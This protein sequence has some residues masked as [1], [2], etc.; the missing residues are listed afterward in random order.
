[1]IDYHKFLRKSKY[2]ICSNI[3]PYLMSNSKLHLE[4]FKAFIHDGE[5]LNEVYIANT[6]S[7]SWFNKLVIKTLKE[8]LMSILVISSFNVT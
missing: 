3:Y 4:F 2:I 7:Q 5:L 6:S 8:K 1:M